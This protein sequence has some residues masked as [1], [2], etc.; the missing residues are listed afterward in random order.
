MHESN[1]NNNNNEAD[2]DIKQN[3]F[4]RVE[5]IYRDFMFLEINPK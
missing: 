1:N 4:L 5:C 3:L 2:K